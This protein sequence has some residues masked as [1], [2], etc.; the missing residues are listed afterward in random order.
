MKL[1]HQY[2]VSLNTFENHIVIKS[3][4]CK[5]CGS[6]YH[7]AMYHKERKPLKRTAMKPQIR[8]VTK[9]Q[10]KSVNKKPKSRSQLI[11]DLD[12][13]FSKWV[14]QRDSGN[15]CITC[16]DKKPAAEMQACHF[17]TRGR[18]ATRWHEDNVHSG[19]YRCNVILKGNYINYTKYM[20]DRYGR[21]FVDDLEFISLNG[22]KISTPVLR[23]KIEFYKSRVL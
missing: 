13:V 2:L 7:T 8:K 17:Y 9:V 10:K 11:K 5:E 18:Q 16:G 21:Q 6:I 12:A 20:I 1:N 22:D 4:P 15:G 19:C 3:K 23:D 14:R